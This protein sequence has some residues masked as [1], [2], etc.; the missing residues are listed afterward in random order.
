MCTGL[1]Y[2]L[3]YKTRFSCRKTGQI[4]YITL[5]STLQEHLNQL[6]VNKIKKQIKQM[7]IKKD[8]NPNLNPLHL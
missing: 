3:N 8:L 4:L 1:K 2:G 7:F 6:N 5:L